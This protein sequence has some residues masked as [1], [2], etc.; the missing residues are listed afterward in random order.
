MWLRR[1]DLSIDNLLGKLR[2]S[3]HPHILEKSRRLSRMWEASFLEFGA[4]RAWCVLGKFKGSAG[5][6][7]LG[8]FLGRDEGGVPE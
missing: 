2:S 5:S 7:S 4:K 1:Q 6:V 3:Q 8:G